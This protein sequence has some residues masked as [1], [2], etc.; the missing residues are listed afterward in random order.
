VTRFLEGVWKE[1]VCFLFRDVTLGYLGQPGIE[2]LPCTG[3]PAAIERRR[4]GECVGVRT[5]PKVFSCCDD[6]KS[7]H[8]K[9]FL[10]PCR[11]L[12]NKGTMMKKNTRIFTLYSIFMISLF[13]VFPQQYARAAGTFVSTRVGGLS[14]PPSLLRLGTNSF[15]IM[16]WFKTA[17]SGTLHRIVSE[18]HKAWS[19]GY[20]LSVSPDL[21]VAACACIGGGVGGGGS[22]AAS[23]LFYTTSTFSTTAWHQ[24]AM[25]IDRTANT[26]RMYLDGK[27]QPITK[28]SG[29]CGTISSDT[30]SL[31]IGSGSNCN[32]S[33]TSTNNPFTIGNYS[34]A[35]SG[36]SEW[37]N[38]NIDDVR[39]YSSAL[40]SQQIL[41]RY[42]SDTLPAPIGYWPLDEG[43]GS[44][45]ADY[46][47]NGNTGTNSVAGTPTNGT[48]V[49]GEVN[50]ALHF[51]GSSNYLNMGISPTLQLAAGTSF[52]I[53]AWFNTS[54]TTSQFRRL[55]SE[56][57]VSVSSG[58]FLLGMSSGCA[59]CI[60][61][62]VGGTATGGSL[63]NFEETTLF[64]D[65]KWHQAALVVDFSSSPNTAQIYI[66]G[67]AQSAIVKVGTT[68]GTLSGTTVNI[69]SCSLT[70][71]NTTDPFTVGGAY[72][73]STIN[74][75]QYFP[76]NLDEVR[77]Y[78]SALSA[79]QVLNQYTS[80][81]NA[82]SETA[83]NASFIGTLGSVATYTLP[84]A[85]NYPLTPAPGWSISITSTTL[86]SGSNTLPTTASSI[87]S[88]TSSP[89]LTNA[90]TLPITI[91]A[92]TVLPSPVQFFSVASGAGNG[93]DTITPTISVTI[94]A[95]AKT[96]TYTS[97]ILLI[98]A[99]GP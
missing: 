98:M 59:G 5:F 31:G 56:G 57:S 44:T 20:F 61:G 32:I 99:D 21:S 93:A 49:T 27:V 66:D 89:T 10:L 74:S 24:G 95:L 60:G 73:N 37:F 67:V 65:G 72:Y 26:A 9:T 19:N 22:V 82:L 8:E 55:V 84:I 62:E 11:N 15:T 58:G 40:N 41:D 51:D 39:I 47:G 36:F 33:A 71:N 18:G 94:P 77:M 80:D 43:S 78:N 96:G 75:L 2:L 81:A 76:G 14:S 63:L 91:P 79:Q 86:T 7:Q 42:T 25:V 90:I 29:T 13:T 3:Y 48:W 88:L 52:T 17:P 64:N 70:P 87:A 16:S 68:C 28:Q 54:S 45:A 92:G 97:T 30:L 85:I 50:D 35:S 38:G 53:M 69:A 34:T 12:T 4:W 46:S 23:V 83:F 6:C 1:D